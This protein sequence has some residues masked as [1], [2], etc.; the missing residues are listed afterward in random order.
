MSMVLVQVMSTLSCYT[1][2]QH[3]HGLGCCK[4]HIR[5]RFKIFC[6]KLVSDRGR[7][8]WKGG[9]GEGWGGRAVR[10]FHARFLCL[11]QVVQMKQTTYITE[12]DTYKSIDTMHSVLWVIE[13]KSAHH[14]RSLPRQAYRLQCCSHQSLRRISSDLFHGFLCK[15]RSPTPGV[16]HRQV[17]HGEIGSEQAAA[18]RAVGQE[19]NA[20][21]PASGH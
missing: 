14:S 2:L 11:Y 17:L 7:G 8:N 9:V 15:A 4:H 16:I 18:H 19:G 3:T 13:C 20:Q 21:L 6:T 1:A 12:R 5:R 10:Q